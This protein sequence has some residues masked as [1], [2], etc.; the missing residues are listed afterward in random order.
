MMMLDGEWWRWRAGAVTTLGRGGSD[1]TCTTIGAALG[2]EEVQVW[3]D[4]DGEWLQ[5]PG[6]HAQ[7]RPLRVAGRMVTS[8]AGPACVVQNRTH[9]LQP[10]A[11]HA[12][13]VHA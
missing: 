7:P 11:L 12:L 10:L 5:D 2:L 1:L 13:A 6:P 4:V 9:R 8:A 3:K